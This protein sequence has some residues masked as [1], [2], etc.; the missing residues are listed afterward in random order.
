MNFIEKIFG[1]KTRK[2][3]EKNLDEVL[4]DGGISDQEILEFKIV[5]L[6]IRL[7]KAKENLKVFLKPPKKI[8]K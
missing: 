2:K 6:E 7:K 1:K 4:K 3:I 5:R 8:K